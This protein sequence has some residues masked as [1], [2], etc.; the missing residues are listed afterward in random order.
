[1]LTYRSGKPSAAVASS[2]VRAIVMLAAVGGVAWSCH[3]G[4]G[5]HG[6]GSGPRLMGGGR[7]LRAPTDSVLA[8]YDYYQWN[9]SYAHITGFNDEQKLTMANSSVFGPKVRLYVSPLLS[10]YTTVGDYAS[11]VLVG[12]AEVYP[13]P[14]GP[15]QKSYHLNFQNSTTDT[16]LYCIYL[17]HGGNSWTSAV[18]PFNSRS[19][20]AAPT[21][22]DVLPVDTSVVTNDTNL[23]D[24]PSVI[25]FTRDSQGNPSIAVSCLNEVCE[26][27]HDHGLHQ[28]PGFS[29]NGVQWQVKTWHDEQLLSVPN[30]HPTPGGP[31][32]TPWLDGMVVPVDTLGNIK[33]MGYA[34]D[35][36][37]V[38]KIW[39]SALPPSKSTY[40]NWG[41]QWSST[42]GENWVWLRLNGRVWEATF[43]VAG[44]PK[45][46]NP[47]K[48]F[49]VTRTNWAPIPVYPTARWVWDDSDDVLWVACD[50]GCC[51]VSGD[52]IQ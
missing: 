27:G 8:F 16:L 14:N 1:M 19:G 17:A 38:A 21:S 47:A 45:P 31:T 9:P 42:S 30:A 15:P 34:Q 29:G 12:M 20:C 44:A 35:W 18:T 32:V 2:V 46:T 23:A 26:I 43:T 11:N 4:G 33:V 7:A 13:N 39:L 52:A 40:D 28:A 3:P 41:L 48:I 6:T 50:Q 37:H 24:F 25:R 5:G 49:A 36:R 22:G 51:T 10:S